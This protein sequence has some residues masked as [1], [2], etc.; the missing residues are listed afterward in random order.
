MKDHL[1]AKRRTPPA[2]IIAM[3]SSN[4]E[5]TAHWLI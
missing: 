4:L 1:L 5:N 2:L 3:Q